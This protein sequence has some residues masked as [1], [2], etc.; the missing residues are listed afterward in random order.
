MSGHLGPHHTLADAKKYLKAKL[1]NG[2]GICPVC[3][4]LAKVYKR[5]IN[6]GMACSLITM[7]R[8]FGLDFG[9]I[10]EL[11]AKS[12][13]EGKLVYW[14]LVAEAHEL[15]PDGGRAGWWR[16]TEKGEAFIRH[17]LTVPKYALIYDG[18]F[19]GYD[20]PAAQIDIR[21]ALTD[22]FNLEDLMAARI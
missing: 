3:T 7:Y 11:P 18:R 16:V 14:G 2:G 6:A 20:N 17:G 22:K 10:P 12:R 21:D 15:R 13:E 9:Y 19:L 5:P 1:L 4:Q 8:T